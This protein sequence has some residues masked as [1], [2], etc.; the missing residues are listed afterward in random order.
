VFYDKYFNYNSGKSNNIYWFLISLDNYI[1]Q[2]VKNISII[3]KENKIMNFFSF[4]KLIFKNLLKKNT[5]HCMNNTFFLSNIYANFFYKTFKSCHFN[6]Y[7]PYENRP[8]QNAVIEVAKNISKKN[9]V[10]GYYHRMPEPL[11][12][13][14]IYKNNFLNKLY[15]CS[16]IQKDVF[17]KYYSWPLEKLEIINSLKYLKFYKKKNII[18]LPYNIEDQNF[19]LK[20]LELLL[21]KTK[22]NIKKHSISIHNLNKNN[23]KHLNFKNS[24]LDV[25]SKNKKDLDASIILGEPGSVAAEMLDTVGK[26]YH[27]SNRDLNIFSEKIWKNIKVKKISDSIFIYTKINKENFLKIN[28]KKNNF[29]T[30]LKKNKFKRC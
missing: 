27:I 11:Q 26:V 9:Q 6:L 28:G 29:E 22:T 23:L 13:E 25:S 4:F 21:F 10:Y 14:M 1:P 15:V 5:M 30:L 19:L 17:K 24:I 7:I 12:L 18:F 3:Y 20:K 2:K 16:K 8:H